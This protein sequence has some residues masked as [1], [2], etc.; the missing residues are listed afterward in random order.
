MN[1][2]EGASKKVSASVSVGGS[3][4][5]GENWSYISYFM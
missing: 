2:L 3:V 1:M 5:G 4:C